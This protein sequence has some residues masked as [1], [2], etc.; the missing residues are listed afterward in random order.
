[1][2]QTKDDMERIA[3]FNALFLKLNEKGQDTALAILHTLGYAQSISN[4]EKSCNL[5]KQISYLKR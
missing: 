2:T 1:M 5:P 3:E 4:T